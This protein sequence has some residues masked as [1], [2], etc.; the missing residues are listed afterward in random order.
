MALK[1]SKALLMNMLHG[2]A[3]PDHLSK[4][5]MEGLDRKVLAK[6]IDE[7]LRREPLMAFCYNHECRCGNQWK[8]FG[9]YGRKT[10]I[11]IPGQARATPIKPL[12][13]TPHNEA[14][15]ETIWQTIEEPVC[16]NCFGGVIVG[17]VAH[18]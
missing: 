6:E 18:G 7:K 13:Y 4:P 9:F 16:L 17:A 1:D 3:L 12:E 15:A 5:R 8:S 10:T 2:T 11:D 14:V